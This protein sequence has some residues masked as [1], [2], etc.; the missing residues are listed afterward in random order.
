MNI[1]YDH[2]KNLPVITPNGTAHDDL[3]QQWV[4]VAD[5]LRT[6]YQALGQAVPNGRDFIGDPDKLAAAREDFV[7]F[8]EQVDKLTAYANGRALAISFG[9]QS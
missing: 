5:A 6:A 3:V 4:A 2:G 8:R 7:D 9:G 1:E